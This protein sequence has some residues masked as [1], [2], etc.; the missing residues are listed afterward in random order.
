M[1]LNLH[2]NL[3]LEMTLSNEAF[4][5]ALPAGTHVNNACFRSVLASVYTLSD[6]RYSLL[7]VFLCLD[8]P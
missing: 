4:N 1:E 5:P 8:S 7:C 2:S 3:T 6:V